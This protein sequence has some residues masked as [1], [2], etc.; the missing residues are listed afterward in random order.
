MSDKAIHDAIHG[1]QGDH[2]AL[3]QLLACYE[4]WGGGPAEDVDCVKFLGARAGDDQ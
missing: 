1:H 4:A 3:S 2:E